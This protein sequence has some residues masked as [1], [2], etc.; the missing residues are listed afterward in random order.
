MGR[1][2]CEVL[3]T[4]GCAS[5]PGR[6]QP[7]RVPA[8]LQKIAGGTIDEIGYNDASLGFDSGTC[9]V[10]NVLQHPIGRHRMGVDT[11]GA[12]DQGLMF[13]LACDR[14]AGTDAA[15][16][17]MLAHKLVRRL[18]EVRRAGLLDFLRPDGKVGRSAWSTWT[19]SR[20]AIDAHRWSPHSTPTS[21]S[22][23]FRAGVRHHVIDP[24]RSAR[25]W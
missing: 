16:P 22:R 20:G 18:S 19:A 23:R 9:G 13:G 7:A 8:G 4:P 14:D 25:K 5:W 17:I 24:V 12:G 11:G 1:V 10:I 3:V 21:P 2:A 15:A 6:S